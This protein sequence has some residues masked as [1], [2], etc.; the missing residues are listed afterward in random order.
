MASFG[1]GLLVGVV[2]AVWVALR[3]RKPDPPAPI[4]KPCIF[5]PAA[6]PPAPIP[7]LLD[8]YVLPGDV[9]PA[10]L[11]MCVLT[12]A[13]GAFSIR[14]VQGTPPPRFVRPHGRGAAEVFRFSHHDDGGRWIYQVE[15]S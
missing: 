14:H 10:P 9:P 7:V 4:V 1:L 2:V 11:T 15:A 13:S 5:R 6:M 12:D 8:A 3:L